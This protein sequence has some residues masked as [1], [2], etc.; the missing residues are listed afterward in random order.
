MAGFGD[1][2]SFLDP[3]FSDIDIPIMHGFTSLIVQVFFSYRI[4]MLNKRLWWL[5]LVISIVRLILPTFC[6]FWSFP[7]ISSLLPKWSGYSWLDWLWALRKLCY[8]LASNTRLREWSRGQ[9]YTYAFL[10]L[11]NAPTGLQLT[12]FSYGLFRLYRRTSWL[13]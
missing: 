5:C 2:R 7:Y 9:L 8:D 13:R 1:V 12:A 11:L 10:A 3:W 4:W 6:K